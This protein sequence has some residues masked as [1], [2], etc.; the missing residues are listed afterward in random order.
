MAFYFHIR[1]ELDEWAVVGLVILFILEALILWSL[2]NNARQKRFERESKRLAL[3]ATEGHRRLDEVVSNVPGIVW[4]SRL[5]P[6]ANQRR[7]TFIS[8]QLKKVLGYSVE[9][10]LATPRFW[11]STIANEDLERVRRES[12]AIFASGQQGSI[13]FQCRKKDGEVIWL[14]SHLAPILNHDGKPVGLRGVTMNVTDRKL[15]EESLAESELRYRALVQAAPQN[16]W[17]TSPDGSFGPLG[18]QWWEK[19][20]GQTRGEWEDLGWLEVIH[21]DDREFVRDGWTTAFNSLKPYNAEYRVRTT[22]GDYGYYAVNAVPVWTKNGELRE[23]V[24]TMSDITTRKKEETLLAGHN[25]VLE[26]IASD[27]SLKNVLESIVLLVEGQFSG[28]LCSILLLDKD[29]IHMRH[30]SA[31]SLP[32][33]YVKAIDGLAI[34]ADVGSCGTAMYSGKTVIVTDILEDP[35]WDDYRSL[36]VASGLRA[37]WSTPVSSN[38]DQVLGSFAVYHRERHVP[39]VDELRL[40]DIAVYLA[41]VAIQRQRTHD[42]LLMSEARFAKAFKANPQPMSITTLNEGRYV[43]PKRG[44]EAVSV[45]DSQLCVI[46]LNCTVVVLQHIV[47]G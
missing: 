43:E 31:P 21:P 42:A 27:A 32:D 17:V 13:T 2:L 45:S 26:M 19:L 47:T 34:G 46:W 37:C 20:T 11:E 41:R 7:E 10:W 5:E 30:G 44:L 3:L 25:R 1:W 40:I 35:L 33:A 8:Q 4:E 39:V 28:M 18:W 16:V 24:G 12:D 23:W 36:A 9:E 6:G 14:E 22:S 29:G 38:D 15:V